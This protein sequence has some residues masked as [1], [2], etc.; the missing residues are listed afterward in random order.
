MSWRYWSPTKKKPKTARNWTS[1]V[2]APARKPWMP[3]NR[4]SS[5]G[6][7]W[8]SPQ[9]GVEPERGGRD[10]EPDDDR[11]AGPAAFVAFDDREHERPDRGRARQ[12][13]AH[14]VAVPAVRVARVRC[15]E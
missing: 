13:A 11:G 2:I 1:T 12:R 8:R 3:N 4:G 6:W 10:G 14:V 7:W 5:S 9:H 15:Q